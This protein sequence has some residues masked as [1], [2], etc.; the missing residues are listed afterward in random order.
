MKGFTNDSIYIYIY[1]FL[2]LTSCSSVMSCCLNICPFFSWS[3]YMSLF[4]S[5]IAFIYLSTLYLTTHTITTALSLSNRLHSWWKCIFH[6]IHFVMLPK[7]KQM[8]LRTSVTILTIA[9]KDADQGEDIVT[10]RL[11]D[12]PNQNKDKQ[13]LI[14][15]DISFLHIIHKLFIILLSLQSMTDCDHLQDLRHVSNKARGP[16]LVLLL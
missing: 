6:I 1:I 11:V 9:I 3:Y 14:M 5:P 15:I 4:I 13:L 16:N 10:C 8:S 2:S 7:L 12:L